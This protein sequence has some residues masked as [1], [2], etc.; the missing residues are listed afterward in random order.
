MKILLF[1]GSYLLGS[2]P[3]GYL[4]VKK[5]EKKDIRMFG[6]QSTGATNVLRVKGWKTGLL[7]GG[8]DVFKGFLPV[9]VAKMIFNDP[10]ISSICA[11]LA[12]TGHCF[13]FAIGFKGGKGVATTLG[14]MAGL[15][16]PVCLIGIAIFVAVI[17]VTRYVSLGSMLA[18]ASFPWLMLIY[19]KPQEWLFGS[20]AISLLILFQH[21]SN[22]KRLISGNE[23]KL[24]NSLQT[25]KNNKP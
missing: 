6:S 22:I 16:L 25:A 9:F 2:I 21:R 3:T 24:G 7:V 18:T 10:L 13:P 1:L 14:A 11:L 17:A 4:A 23:R 12:V 5:S 15:S 19:S 20:I 8:I